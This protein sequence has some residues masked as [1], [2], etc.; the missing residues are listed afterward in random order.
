MTVGNY[1]ASVPGVVISMNS[2]IIVSAVLIPI[3]A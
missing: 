1:L 3:I 2:S